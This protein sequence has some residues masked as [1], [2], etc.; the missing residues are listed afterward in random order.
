MNLLEQTK[1]LSN[2]LVNK[3]SDLIVDVKDATKQLIPDLKTEQQTETITESGVTFKELVDYYIQQ[4]Q[5]LIESQLNIG[6][7]IEDHDFLMEK[8]RMQN[9]YFYLRKQNQIEICIPT[10]IILKISSKKLQDIQ[11]DLQKM[12]LTE[13]TKTIFNF[14]IYNKQKSNF[15]QLIKQKNINEIE[16]IQ[17]FGLES[18][19]EKIKST[20]K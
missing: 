20:L 14:L 10:H 12:K 8:S 16:A 13:E 1:K 9:M 3:T 11:T 4:K 2:P 17:C 19:F 5:A 15:I 7:F 6:D 18:L